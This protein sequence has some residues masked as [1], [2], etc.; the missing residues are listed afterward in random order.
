MQKMRLSLFCLLLLLL[1]SC[2]VQ[3]QISRDANKLVLQQADLA[4]AHIGIALFNA[5]DGKFLFNHQ[6]DKYFLPASNTKI[7]T[8]YAAMRYLGDSIPGLIYAYDTENPKNVWI[9]PT[10][11]PTFLHPDFKRQPISDFLLSDT[12]RNYHWIDPPFAT[13]AW[14]N[15]WA[16]NDQMQ[17]YMPERSTFPVGGN[18]L[19]LKYEKGR[20]W[21]APANMQFIAGRNVKGNALDLSSN[22]YTFNREAN[23]NA[24][25]FEP[26][27]ANVVNPFSKKDIPFIT[28]PSFI[29]DA[30]QSTLPGV[31]LHY[32]AMGPNKGIIPT[33]FVHRIQ[34]QP[35]D[36]LLRPMMYRS[37]NFFAE[38]LLLMIAQQK[39]GVMQERK[40]IDT[41]L[42]NDLK[43]LPQRPSWVDGS[44]LSR[45]N[46]FTPQSIVA[47]L[48]KM[49]KEFA[50]ERITTLFPTGGLGTIGS[51]Y[52]HL[53]G[54]IF[55]KTGS[56]S[57]QI[58]LSGYLITRKQ[59]MILFSVLVNNH[60]TT[61]ASVRKA[62]ESFL[63]NIY[64]RY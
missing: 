60:Q 43:D 54:K 38:Q 3:K 44:G 23:T 1:S 41:L 2:S 26:M 59:H 58:A 55:A 33:A 28:H 32:N 40:L 64:E 12:S 24:V 52:Q 19:R 49:R 11:D 61:A 31:K 4:K 45:Y 7:F 47:V 18:V 42:A 63:T 30:I 25:V 56:L 62:V 17:D 37:D 13:T 46:L 16:W 21:Y 35:T 29:R 57:G 36:S 27:N 48:D 39:W 8:L 20:L 6:A 51:Y 15:G 22:R 53:S 50:W 5:T 34:S 14:G 10:G 9:Q